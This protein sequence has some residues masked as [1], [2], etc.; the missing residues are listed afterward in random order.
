MECDFGLEEC[1]V[2]SAENTGNKNDDVEDE[3]I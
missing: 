2:A 3:P 1:E